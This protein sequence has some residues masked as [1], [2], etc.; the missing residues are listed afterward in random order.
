MEKE[1]EILVSLKEGALA[2]DLFARHVMTLANYLA[3]R[4]DDEGLEMLE[5]VVTSYGLVTEANQKAIK[6]LIESKD[7]FSPFPFSRNIQAPL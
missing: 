6:N 5:K 2:N 3:N 7:L 1:L 4:K